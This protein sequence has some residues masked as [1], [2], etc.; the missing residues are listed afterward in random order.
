MPSDIIWREPLRALVGEELYNTIVSS[1]E[2]GLNT[3]YPLH[4]P[5][6]IL[7]YENAGKGQVQDRVSLQ[8]TRVSK[9]QPVHW[10]TA[11]PWFE[12]ER[13]R[14]AP[15]S[16]ILHFNDGLST[17]LA[18]EPISLTKMVQTHLQDENPDVV[19]VKLTK[20]LEWLD[21]KRKRHSRSRAGQCL[22]FHAGEQPHSGRGW[23]GVQDPI[24]KGWVG[25]VVAYF[26][27]VPKT[28]EKK[29]WDLQVLNPE[30]PIGLMRAGV[31]GKWVL[32]FFIFCAVFLA[33]IVP[34]S[35]KV[36]K[37]FR[38]VPI[39]V[40]RPVNPKLFFDPGSF[41]F[42]PGSLR[43]VVFVRLFSI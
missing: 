4:A 22:A 18:S 29:T 36:K 3:T 9:D 42:D 12:D 30:F 17:H 35:K 11:A 19:A 32:S 10:D 8:I 28:V 1:V 40:T 21:E 13:G 14:W 5:W 39:Q 43:N 20:L 7:H 16:V 41:F 33:W 2:S 37:S 34:G 15:L 27:A 24:K 26:F 6:K 38:R 31:S 25:R 23:D